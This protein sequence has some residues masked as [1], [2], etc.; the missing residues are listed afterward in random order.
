MV[1]S[2]ADLGAYVTINPNFVRVAL[3]TYDTETHFI[4]GDFNAINNSNHYVNEI[5][6]LW[7]TPQAGVFGNNIN[8]YGVLTETFQQT[9]MLLFQRTPCCS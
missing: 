9:S 5:L 4:P 7:R 6:Q 2:F 8:E 1:L 3:G